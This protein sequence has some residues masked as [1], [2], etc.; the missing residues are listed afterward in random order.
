M[1]YILAIIGAVLW[2]LVSMFFTIFFWTIIA[3]LIIGAMIFAIPSPYSY[4]LFIIYIAGLIVMI[5]KIT[6]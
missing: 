2:F 1:L 5:F 3:L 6:K 4:V